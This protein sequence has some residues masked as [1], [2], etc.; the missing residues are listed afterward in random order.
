MDIINTNAVEVSIQA[1]SPALILS[2]GNRKGSVGAAG[3]AAAAVSAAPGAVALESAAGV[4]S[5][6]TADTAAVDN[7]AA[8]NKTMQANRANLIILNPLNLLNG[9][10]VSLTR[11]DSHHLD[12]IEH[13]NFPVA[14]LA[15]LCRFHDGIDHLVEQLII[16]RNL[17][18][19]LRYE[20][21]RV[22]RAAVDLGVPTLPTEALHLGH[23]NT[24]HADVADGLANIFEFERLYDGGNEFHP[25][26]P[27]LAR[28][29]VGAPRASTGCA[30]AQDLN[31][32][33]SL[34]EI[35][36]KIA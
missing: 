12:E 11:P 23:R 3:A 31:A 20:L 35:T 8:V 17:Y 26:I 7:T 13:E 2:T 5:A 1:V 30:I 6:Q 29:R 19:C 14:D 28:L 24:L 25:C 21:H 33:S 34:E 36:A 4:S 18:F 9:A 32:I 27:A 16:N 22:L 10:R 15:R